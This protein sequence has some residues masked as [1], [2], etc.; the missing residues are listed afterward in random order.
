[1][2][3]MRSE[4]ENMR[5]VQVNVRLTEGGAA[6]VALDLHKR[7][8]AHG[9]A[10]QFYYGYGRGARPNPAAGGITGA[11]Q[12]GA[13]P[14]VL[15]NYAVHSWVGS[16]PV[17]PLGK[18]AAEFIAAVKAADAVHLHVTH[19]YFLPLGWLARMLAAHARRVVWTAHDN[20]LL[21][22]RCAVLDGCERWTQG[23]G[24]CRTGVNYPPSRLD[25]SGLR[26]PSKLALVKSL[27][28]KLTIV[29]PSGFLK[30]KLERV[31]PGLDV[32]LVPNSIDLDFEAQTG[33][34]PA[35][36][37]EILRQPPGKPRLLVIAAD[38]SQKASNGPEL[39][40]AMRQSAD[41]DLVTIGANSPFAGPGVINLGVMTDR[42]RLIAVY[43]TCDA[44]LFTSTIDNAPL[45]LIEALATGLPVLAVESEAARD[46]LALVGGV[47]FAT[48]AQAAEQLRNLDSMPIFGGRGRAQIAALAQ[49]AFSGTTLVDAYRRMYAGTATQA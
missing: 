10:S 15:A 20:W 24:K 7:L 18:R 48:P 36:L 5:I 25:F 37:P 3:K 11:R 30:R 39:A 42:T 27:G 16:E 23:C 34:P 8:L 26:R 35:A 21:T 45:V 29:S 43:R 40:A 6:R 44:M 22:G 41:F 33:G 38:L 28:G 9:D 14:A 46:M 17:P 19:S 13:R 2:H 12:L 1:M 4:P 32:R 31:Y 49:K 47:P